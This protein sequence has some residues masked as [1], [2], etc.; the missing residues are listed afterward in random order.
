MTANIDMIKKV[1]NELKQKQDYARKIVGRPLTLAE[2]VLYA[3]FWEEPK[4][5]LERGK[6]YVLARTQ[7]RI[8][9]WPTANHE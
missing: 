8:T 3:H 1:Y 9:V 5:E 7:T 2:K 6:D 4:K